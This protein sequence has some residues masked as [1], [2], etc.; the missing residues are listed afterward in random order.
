MSLIL[1]HPVAHLALGLLLTGSAC[2]EDP[3]FTGNNNH[4][5][6]EGEP[7]GLGLT[8]NTMLRKSVPVTLRYSGDSLEIDSVSLTRWSTTSTE[9]SLIIEVHNIGAGT[10]C[11]LSSDGIQLTAAG[12]PVGPSK[13]AFVLGSVGVFND[14]QRSSCLAPDE[15]GYVLAQF[16]EDGT[17]VYDEVDG[18]ELPLEGNVVNPLDPDALVIPQAY[19]LA[20]LPEDPSLLQLEV[21]LTNEGQ[22]SARVPSFSD[23]AW[24]LLDDQG[25]GLSWGYLWGP[26]FEDLSLAS[27]DSGS[28]VDPLCACN[29][30][31]GSGSTVE[32][33]VDFAAP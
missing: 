6:L 31:E 14:R 33:R 1:R 11:N 30:F 28:L 21:D 20:P 25:Q 16:F 19:S 10:Q 12:V 7:V 2:G 15:T 18:V 26:Q 8:D 22:G 3:P 29:L 27:G 24:I 17:P 13:V 23:S 32:V 4:A 9:L 5:R